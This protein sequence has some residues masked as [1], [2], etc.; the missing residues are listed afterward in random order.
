MK[1]TFILVLALALTA[2][3]LAAQ[4]R[5]E[6]LRQRLTSGR[7]SFD[8][9]LTVD[10]KV[11]VKQSGNAVIDGD[12]YCIK[13]NGVE[14]HCDGT[15]L[16]TVDTQ[17]L[18]VYIENSGSVRE[19]LAD[20]AAYLDKIS[21]LKVGETTASGVYT[22]AGNSVKFNLSSIRSSES[23][24]DGAIFKFDTSALGEEWVITDLR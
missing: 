7:V 21:G 1:K 8:Y 15:T 5:V 13:G 16:W 23:G 18:E 11:P 2:L 12:R 20:P 19:F 3:S 14:I 9:I 22:D 4:D 10:G 6:Q 17:A 24:G